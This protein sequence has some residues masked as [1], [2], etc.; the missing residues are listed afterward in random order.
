MYGVKRW[1]DAHREHAQFT[2]LSF[3]TQADIDD[4]SF[5]ILRVWSGEE[6]GCWITRLVQI[7]M[8]S[9]KKDCKKML[10]CFRELKTN[11]N[12]LFCC[13][14]TKNILTLN[15][16]YFYTILD[17]Y[18]FK[19]S[20]TVTVVA[21]DSISCKHWT[22]LHRNQS[23]T[24]YYYSNT[25][26]ESDPQI[27][28]A[29][30]TLAPQMS[31]LLRTPSGVCRVRWCPALELDGFRTSRVSKSLQVQLPRAPSHTA[32]QSRCKVAARPPCWCCCG[33]AWPCL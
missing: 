19:S 10:N 22:L 24:I 9:A 6:Y 15:F 28:T 2:I 31:L 25:L 8:F 29:V 4:L 26:S 14:T 1:H 18:T 16:D 27:H 5:S 23:M 33:T 3:S 21:L 20:I 30:F 7:D 32:R 12:N 13:L 11:R 17:I